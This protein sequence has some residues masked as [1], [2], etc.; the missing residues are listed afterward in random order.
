[1]RV[2]DRPAS[3]DDLLSDRTSGAAAIAA[4]AAALVPGRPR[5]ELAD[6]FE[7]V[8]RAHPSMAPLWRLAS[9]VLAASDPADAAERFVAGLAAE[10]E[11]IAAAAA[12]LLPDRVLTH[13]S[14]STVLAALRL[15][16]PASVLC[17]HSLPG[18]E[19]TLMTAA[20]GPG[21]EAETIADE[22]AT[23]TI[24]AEADAVV[25]GADAVT[26][27]AVINK[28][29][30][31]DLADAATRARVPFFVLAGSSRLVAEELPVT[32]LFDTT[33]LISVSGIVTEGGLILPRAA[34]ARALDAKLLPALRLLIPRL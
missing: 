34:R 10:Q 9:Q 11:A 2:A 32:D 17:T 13:S 23:R 18:G 5:E 3:I 25:V 31:R 16:R 15:R 26:P 6:L 30:T 24:P 28:V 14:S 22:L 29:R 12:P 1:V 4:H 7:A 27:S 33:P 21:I 8:L 19:G 20:L